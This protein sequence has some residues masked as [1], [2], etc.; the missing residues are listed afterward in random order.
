MAFVNPGRHTQLPDISKEP[1]KKH[2]I[3]SGNE[4]LL[5]FY[6]LH[7]PK[8]SFGLE[9]LFGAAFRGNSINSFVPSGQL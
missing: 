8:N 6:L 5:T 4:P 1:L 7:F 3:T 9:N 2:L